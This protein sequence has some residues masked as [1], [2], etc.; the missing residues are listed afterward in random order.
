M[1][2][3]KEDIADTVVKIGATIGL[4]INFAI[5]LGIVLLCLILIV[6]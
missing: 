2:R 5:G 6:L 3:P 1:K 4:A